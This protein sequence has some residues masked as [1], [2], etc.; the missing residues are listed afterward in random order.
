MLCVP[1]CKYPCSVLEALFFKGKLMGIHLAV[2]ILNAFKAYPITPWLKCWVP[3]CLHNLPSNFLYLLTS[4]FWLFPQRATFHLVPSVVHHDPVPHSAFHGAGCVLGGFERTVF[5]WD[6]T[7]ATAHAEGE[8][9][10][11]WAW[12]YFL[13][14]QGMTMDDSQESGSQSDVRLNN[15]SFLDCREIQEM[16]LSLR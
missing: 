2:G 6:G 16:I 7:F 12:R 15:F 5:R 1:V 8:S 11:W 10:A 9:E 13:T 4:I 3:T 14:N